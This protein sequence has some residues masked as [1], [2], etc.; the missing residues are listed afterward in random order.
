M[1]R[2]FIINPKSGKNNKA[3]E[4]E[5][6]IKTQFYDAD[7]VYTKEAGHAKK[8]AAD[9][10][11]QGYEQ[12]IVAGGDGTINEAASSL[13]GTKTYLGIIPLGSGNGLAREI[14]CPV[15]NLQKACNNIYMAKP[16]LCDAG[17]ANGEYFFNVAGIGLEATIAHAFAKVKT[18]GMWPYF[19]IGF[20][21]VLKYKAPQAEV[22]ADDKSLIFLNPITLVFANGRQYGSN[23]KIAP[24]ASLTDG[25]FDMVYVGQNPLWKLALGLPNFFKPGFSSL[26]LSNTRQIKKA[27]ITCQ[28]KFVY[29]LDGEPK[30]AT[31]KLEIEVVPKAI[32]LLIS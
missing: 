20:S 1:K 21:Q 17:K 11:K 10:V 3:S 9:A 27:T 32:Y 15:D 26:K 25:K 7:I 24:K 16:V 4:L 31:D 23:F 6:T 30:E 22:W 5:Q 19:K 29:H 13:V 28:G 14:G 12:V 2:L 8:L 18:R